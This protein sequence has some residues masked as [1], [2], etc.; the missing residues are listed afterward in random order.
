MLLKAHNIDFITVH[1]CIIVDSQNKQVTL[2]LMNQVM[3]TEFEN[4]LIKEE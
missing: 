1:D 4:F 3:E 2:N